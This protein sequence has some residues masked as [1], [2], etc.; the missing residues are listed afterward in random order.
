MLF[1]SFTISRSIDFIRRWS[2]FD[3]EILCV[4]TMTYGGTQRFSDAV[5]YT[6]AFDDIYFT[7]QSTESGFTANSIETSETYK[8]IT[9]YA[10]HYRSFVTGIGGVTVNP[11]A[12]SIYS[13]SKDHFS[14]TQSRVIL[15][16][17]FMG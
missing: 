6:T 15:R 11:D 14:I 16:I 12:S 7:T 5:F 13:K 17:R 3:G 8:V 2:R 4:P 9:S 10:S 1:R